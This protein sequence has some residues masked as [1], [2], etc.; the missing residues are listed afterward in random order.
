MQTRGCPHPKRELLWARILSRCA[1]RG[2]VATAQTPE[3]EYAG[4]FLVGGERGYDFELSVST[5]FDAARGE[6]EI[7]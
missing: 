6:A 1:D 3:F 2:L 7:A 4:N 5:G